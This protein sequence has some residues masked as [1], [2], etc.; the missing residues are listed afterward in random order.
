MTAQ[1]KQRKVVVI[2]GG[3]GNSSVLRGLKRYPFAITAIVT[4]FDSGSSSGILR[5]EFGILPPGDVRQCLIALA[6]EK[7]E[8]MLRELFAYRFKNG[9][10]LNGHS[11]GNLFLTA[12]THILK[13]DAKAIKKAGELLNI[14]GQVLPVSLDN[15]HVHAR[16]E[17]GTI[18]EGETNISVPKHDGNLKV[19]EVFLA[20]SAKL[21]LEAKKAIVGA[22][23]V[24]IGPGGLYSSLIPNLL[25]EGM[26]EA[27]RKSRAKKIYIMNLMTRWGE[28]NNL[29]ASDCAREILSYARIEKFDFIIC[30]SKKVSKKVMGAYAKEKKYPVV[31]D[32]DLAKYGKKIVASSLYKGDDLLRHDS[33]ALAKIIASL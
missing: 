5:D 10:T 17:D 26:K 7:K 28:T 16:L 20:P 33:D 1:Q 8:P 3:T 27:L 21:F 4:M 31:L 18:I 25:V 24:I 22:D 9:G 12:L 6:E 30:N 23:L 29:S 19:K 32:D 2:G 15:A 11:F 13:D 14:N